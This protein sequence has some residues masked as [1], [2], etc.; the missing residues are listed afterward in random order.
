MNSRTSKP[1]KP[2]LTTIVTLLKQMD[3]KFETKLEDVRETVE[4]LKDNVPMRDEVLTKDEAATKAELVEFKSDVISHI[5]HFVQLHEKQDL[6][7]V[8][9][10]H[11][12]TRHEEV[13]HPKA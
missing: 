3:Q 8:A 11:R 7:L 13:F 5:D 2:T 6:E 10:S 12:M 9:L 4:F 1:K